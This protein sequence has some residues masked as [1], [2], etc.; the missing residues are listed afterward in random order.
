MP[1]VKPKPGAPK[2]RGQQQDPRYDKVLMEPGKYEVTRQS[3]FTVRVPLKRRSEEDGWWLVVKE[4]ES[5]VVEQVVFRMWEYDEMVEMRKLATKYDQVRRV[6]MIDHDVLNRL[7]VQRFMVSWTFGNDN[8]RL[9]LHHQNGVLTDESW[10]A[11]K[12]LQTNILSHLIQEMNE[13]YEFGG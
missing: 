1:T 5:E 11:V 13:K 12:K 2:P 6:H 4:D 7:K 10:M 3:T 9:Q 8:P